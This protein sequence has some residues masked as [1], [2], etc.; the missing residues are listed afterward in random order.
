MFCIDVRREPHN[1]M[2]Y[3]EERGG[4]NIVLILLASYFLVSSIYKQWH[5]TFR[6][7]HESLC[8]EHLALIPKYVFAV[9]REP[10][11][12]HHSATPGTSR[13]TLLPDLIT[14]SM[15]YVSYAVVGSVTFF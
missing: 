10:C 9:S 11:Y 13:S 3:I 6:E 8:S 14:C 7:V 5:T 12:T 4:S 1:M 2:N 15:L